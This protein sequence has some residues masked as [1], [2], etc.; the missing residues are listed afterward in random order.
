MPILKFDRLVEF[1]NFLE[2]RG[3]R[4]LPEPVLK[5]LISFYFGRAEKW[6]KE[7]L[8][9]LKEYDLVRVVGYDDKIGCNI[10]DINKESSWLKL[11]YEMNSYK[12]KVRNGLKDKV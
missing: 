1:I 6:T 4:K 3:Y 9:S 5:K 8:K 7:V 12:F 10:Y 11:Y 2:E